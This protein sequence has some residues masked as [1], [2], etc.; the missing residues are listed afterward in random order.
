MHEQYIGATSVELKKKGIINDWNDDGQCSLSM[1]HELRTVNSHT[2]IGNGSE[3]IPRAMREKKMT[4]TH[5]ERSVKTLR[6]H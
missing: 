1:E 5:R 6:S 2:P 4:S 3:F